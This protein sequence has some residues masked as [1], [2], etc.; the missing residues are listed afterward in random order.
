M[1]R[2]TARPVAI[3]RRCNLYAK[4]RRI[5]INTDRPS[6]IYTYAL[7]RTREL[8]AA[9]IINRGLWMEFMCPRATSSPRIFLAFILRLGVHI[10]C[11]SINGKQMSHV[12]TTASASCAL[13]LGKHE[14]GKLDCP[15]ARLDRLCASC[16][17]SGSCE[18]SNERIDLAWHGS[19]FY[20]H[21]FFRK[22]WAQ[23]C[24]W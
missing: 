11:C 14:A 12:P 20:L 10:T 17:L 21:R 16:P 2:P 19:I 18:S 9:S 22:N 8:I 7:L 23:L 1:K 24:E 13:A 15:V 6:V 4:D 5:D 3:I